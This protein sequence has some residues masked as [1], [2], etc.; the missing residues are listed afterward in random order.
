M[1]DKKDSPQKFI[2]KPYKK[3]QLQQHHMYRKESVI[4]VSNLIIWFRFCEK[5]N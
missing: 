3:L 1:E 4:S 5:Q 2:G